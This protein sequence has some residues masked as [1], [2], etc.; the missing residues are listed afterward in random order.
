MGVVISARPGYAVY[1]LEFGFLA[2]AV[3]LGLGVYSVIRSRKVLAAERRQRG[4]KGKVQ[5]KTRDAVCKSLLKLGLD[6]RPARRG[7][8]EE[9]TGEG[10]LGLIDIPGET[11]EWAN[12]RRVTTSGSGVSYRTDFGVPDPKLSPDFPDVRIRSVYKKTFPMFGRVIDL[13]WK[14]EDFGLGIIS[15][16]NSDSSIKEPILSGTGVIIRSHGR[17]GCWTIST[18]TLTIPSPALWSCYRTVALHLLASVR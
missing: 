9:K 1:I 12:V 6:V 7:R 14:G 10:S 15:R 11:V 16:L 8:A 3:P 2:S 4:I 5:D 17:Y 13:H 18:D